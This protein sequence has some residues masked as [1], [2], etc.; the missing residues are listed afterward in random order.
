MPD[1]TTC[2]GPHSKCIRWAVS[3]STDHATGLLPGAAN[4]VWC[5]SGSSPRR[6]DPCF[7]R[8]DWPREGARESPA[9]PKIQLFARRRVL[10]SCRMA[11]FRWPTRYA[12][13][14]ECHLRDHFCGQTLFAGVFCI[15]GWTDSTHRSSHSESRSAHTGIANPIC[16]FTLLTG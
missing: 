1:L 6:S 9:S 11:R 7:G 8:G 4:V 13:R 16:N 15:P 5:I 14:G 12:R 2:G 3:S 10:R